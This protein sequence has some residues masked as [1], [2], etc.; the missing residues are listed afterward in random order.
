MKRRYRLRCSVVALAAAGMVLL[1]VV[2]AG[3][4][5]AVAQPTAAGTVQAR[6]RVTLVTLGTFPRDLADAVEAGLRAELA[7]DVRRMN[8]RPLPRAAFYPPR[9]R[10][11]AD[12]LLTH[13]HT[14]V[15][16]DPTTTRILGMTS[17]DISTTKGRVYD[18]GVFGLGDLGGTACVISVFRLRRSARDAE[19]L[20][21]RIVTTAIHEVGH[22]LGLDHCT[23][24]R[25]VMRDAEG[26]ITTVDTSTGR[27]GP[28][29]RARLDRS[30]PVRELA[31]APGP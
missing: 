6:A 31:M 5:A 10:Y 3:Q 1:A 11:R 30:A 13:L 21:F 18:W 20:R 2:D 9:H 25:C 15:P 16:G 14:L 22:T 26:S 24:P 17:V 19:H 7:V 29:C 8:D 23:E 27:L 12:R 4:S 28:E